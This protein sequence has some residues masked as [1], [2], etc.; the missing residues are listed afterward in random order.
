VDKEIDILRS[1]L[2]ELGKEN[3]I[4]KSRLIELQEKKIEICKSKIL[5]VE[6]THEQKF[7]E[8]WLEMIN[9]DD[10][11]VMPIGGENTS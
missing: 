5:I 11:Q 6:G 2:T 9:R 8:K 3:E 1:K 7:F 10:I 4:L